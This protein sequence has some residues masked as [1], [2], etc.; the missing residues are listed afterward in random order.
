MTMAGAVSG[1]MSAILLDLLKARRA[2]RR[3]RRSLYTEIAH[4]A[5][6]LVWFRA[7]VSAPP[8]QR[9]TQDVLRRLTFD[10]Y[11]EAHRKLDVF[12]DLE[13]VQSIETIY[14]ALKRA[15]GPHQNDST[16]LLQVN[17]ATRAIEDGVRHGALKHRILEK[18]CPGDHQYLRDE[19]RRMRKPRVAV[20]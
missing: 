18:A 6:C 3:L 11:E 15:A 1:F 9:V 19:F 12:D 2:K 4:N 13:E 5:G 17:A 7:A 16:A 20:G 10:R 8:D 14:R